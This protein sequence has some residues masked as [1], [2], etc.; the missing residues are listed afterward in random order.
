[1]GMIRFKLDSITAFRDKNQSS[2]EHHYCINCVREEMNGQVLIP[3][4]EG[5]LSA[6][7]RNFGREMA[8]MISCDKCGEIMETYYPQ[9]F[10]KNPQQTTEKSRDPV[11]FRKF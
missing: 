9:E 6:T 3:F 1:M 2:N 10:W 11:L 8:A 5:Q 7:L 4:L